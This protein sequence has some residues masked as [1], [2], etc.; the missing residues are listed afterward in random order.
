MAI[1]F[2]LLFII[3][4]ISVPVLIVKKV[5]KDIAIPELA[6]VTC[7]VLSIGALCIG[8]MIHQ[9]DYLTAIDPVDG[10]CYIPFGGKHILTLLFYFAAFHTALL[11]IWLKGNKL[12]PLAMVLCLGFII[13]GIVFNI[14]ILFQISEHDTSSL[15]IYNHAD[16]VYLFVFTP[17]LGIF[18]S[19]LLIVQVVKTD[20]ATAN[21]RTYTNKLLNRLNLFL[22]QQSN[23]PFWA[24]ILIIPV[25]LATTVLLMLLGQ[26][27]DSLVKVFTETTTWRFSQHTHPPVLGHRGHYLCTVAVSGNPKIV[28]PIRLGVRAGR[29]IVV[30][31]Q[32][33][34][35]NAFEEM[36]QDF[37]P[38]LH[39]IIRRNYDTYGYNLSK[40]INN[41]RM[42]N[43]TY[44]LMKPLEWF[45]LICLY[46]FSEKPEQRINRQYPI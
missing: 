17:V 26:D 10:A 36:V 9:A 25:L 43:L 20:M 15:G 18:I 46:L 29:I 44:F 12:P 33:L 32:L 13:T 1:V 4:V 37:S 5:K 14:L 6:L 11:L 3:M 2:A 16:H 8:F 42:S 38:G 22:A 30:N 45:F 35:A 34:I 28:K 23:L 7:Y 40:K 27:P 24:V 39:R 41:E 19:A 21:D 31:R